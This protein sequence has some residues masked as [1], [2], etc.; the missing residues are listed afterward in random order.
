MQLTHHLRIAITGAN[1]QLGY[2]LVKSLTNKVTLA[3]F[4][5][6]DLNITDSEQVNVKLMAFAPDIIINAAA[7]TAVD[8]AEQE[9]DIA[10][11]VN[12]EGPENLAKVATILGAILI[13]VSTDYVFDGNSC[14][15]YEEIDNTE[16]QSIYGLSKLNGEHAV[17]KYCRKHIILRTAW[18]FSCYGNNFVKTMLR[19]AN[20]QK[21]IGVVSDQIG[22]PTYAGDVS[23]AIVSI[24]SQLDPCNDKRFGIYHYSGKPYVSWYEFANEIFK[25]ATAQQIIEKPPQLNPIG[26]EQYI[27]SAKRP[28]YSML[29][30][31]KVQQTFDITPS[32][33]K[34][35]LENLTIYK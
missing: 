26:T 5:K 1:G 4:D 9:P 27:T 3:A 21:E 30:C 11:A 6:H 32:D 20:K 2:H 15:P 12:E 29:N 19:L 24:I 23:D 17:I 35:A 31:L 33:W 7:Y 34:K 8:K 16:P 25:Q 22:G 18:L 10:K 28:A 14:K 13:H